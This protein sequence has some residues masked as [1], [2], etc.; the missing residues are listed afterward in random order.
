MKLVEKYEYLPL[1]REDGGPGGRKYVDP[2]GHRLP[3]VTT[4][5][6]RTKT[7]EARKALESWRRSVGEKKANEITTEAAFRGTLM[8]SY[9][10]K[11]LKGDNPQPGTNLYHKQSHKMAS[12]II[13]QY[14]NPFID[15]IWGLETNLYYPELYA[16]TTDMV[17]SYGGIPSI[18]DFKQT[19]KPKTDE[20][21]HD[22]KLQLA[23]YAAAHNAV[24]GT[25]ITQ[26]VI[27]MCSKDLQPQR[28]ILSGTE[29][30]EYSQRWW[31]RV[32][33]YHQVS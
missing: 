30:E 15:E 4:I 29:F 10:E 26:G 21:V 12:I 3:S 24:Y 8:H 31:L 17:G 19:N 32:A 33:E 27:L 18:I 9:L 22:Y 16:G 5:L 13:E 11:Y 14:L 7:E 6:D 20:R 2:L 28:W 1:P 25:N 23:A